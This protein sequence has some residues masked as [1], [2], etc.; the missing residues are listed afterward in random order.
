[1]AGYWNIVPKGTWKILDAEDA[2]LALEDE[3][4]R[5]AYDSNSNRINILG[6]SN[7]AIIIDLPFILSQLDY[8][9]K[10]LF[11]KQVEVFLNCQI[12]P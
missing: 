11:I 12:M 5:A 8:P 2:L 6:P 9:S 10:L 1:M 7:K 3:E 4:S